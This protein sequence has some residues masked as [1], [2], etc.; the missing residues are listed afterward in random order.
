[1]TELNIFFRRKGRDFIN[2]DAIDLT[3]L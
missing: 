2:L 1:M 3:K